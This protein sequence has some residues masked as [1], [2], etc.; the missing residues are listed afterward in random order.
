MKN[1][2]KKE[3]N[4]FF[5]LRKKKRKETQIRFKK[6]IKRIWRYLARDSY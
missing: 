2:M 3:K 1:E 5:F 6:I 4:F